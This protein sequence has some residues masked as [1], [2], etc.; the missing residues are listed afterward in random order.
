MGG[1]RKSRLSKYK[2]DRLAKHFDTGTTAR[3]AGVLCGVNRKTA[4]Y[5]FH[6]LREIVAYPK[7]FLTIW[8]RGC[9]RNFA[10]YRANHPASAYTLIQTA[11][12]NRVDP[13]AWLTDV[14]D[15]IAEH[16]TTAL[17]ELLPWRYAEASV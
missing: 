3:T 6:R 13:Q 7:Q 10:R 4:A 17:D 12:P 11:K 5:Y 8:K 15:Y 14:L 1:E 2:Q 16:K 9:S